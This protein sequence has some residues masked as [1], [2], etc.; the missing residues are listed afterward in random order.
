MFSKFWFS[1][2]LGGYKGKKWSK[3]R[4]KYVCHIPHLKKHTSYDFHLWYTKNHDHMLHCS[5]DMACDGC[6]CYF[7]FWAIFCPF[8]LLTAQKFKIKKKNEK[9]SPEILSFYT[10]VTKIMII[11]YSSWDMVRD[12]CNCYFSFWAIFLPFYPL[13]AQKNQNF[14]KMKR[15]PGDIIIF[16]MCTKHYDQ[17]TYSSWDMVHNRQTDGRTEKVTYIGGCPA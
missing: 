12:G 7:S 4:K 1:G 11:C 5:W 6:N 17:M 13:T 8:I 16:H 9:K 3:M 15:A 14:I 2:L 10:S